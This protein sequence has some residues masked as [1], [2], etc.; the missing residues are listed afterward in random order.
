MPIEIPTTKTAPVYFPSDNY[1][2]VRYLDLVKFLS[3][4]Q[5]NRLYFSRLDKFEDNYEGTVPELTAKDYKEWY[6]YFTKNH[7]LDIISTSV[8]EHV[9]QTIAE[10]KEAKEKYKKLVCVSC[11]N[12]YNSES[13][14]LWKIYSDLSKGV[15]ITTSIERLKTAFRDT[16]E[17]IQLSEIKYLDYKKDKM[18]LGNMNYPIIHKSIHY[19]YEKEIRLIYKVP[20]ESGLEYDWSKEENQFGKYLD[21]DVNTLIEEI[22]VSPKAPQW[23]FDIISDLLQ[24]YNLKK[25]IKYSDLK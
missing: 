23:F 17:Q 18:Q 3:L 21:V 1:K 8:E 14:A 7:L 6:T 19:D 11:W 15:M 10:E 2:I 9:E 24:K 4:I 22:I 16:D 12:K 20:F 13:Y 5:T 25:E